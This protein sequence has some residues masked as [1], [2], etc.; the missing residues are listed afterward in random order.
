MNIKRTTYMKKIRP[1]FNKQLIKVLTGQRRVGKS[2]LMLQ[3]MEELRSLNK[4]AN[5]IYIDKE[6]HEFKNII[7]DD[8]LIRYVKENHDASVKNYLFIDEV[9]EI[10]FFE[11]ALRDLVAD[12]VFDIYCTGSN[13]QMFS[14]EL[15]TLLSGRQIELKIYP[16]SYK[17]LLD[18]HKFDN[19]DEALDYYLKYGGLPFLIHLEKDESV[20][21]DYLIN[22]LS[23]IIFR[24]VVNR[25]KV[26]D[27]AFLDSLLSFIA[28]NTGSLFSA[29]KI[30]AYLKSQNISK[31]V[32]SVI[33]YMDYLELA[34]IISKLK[35]MDVQGKKIFEVGGKYYFEDVGLRNTLVGFK[36][37]DINK[38]IEN[39]V[40]NH[41]R[42]CGYSVNIGRFGN[43]EIDFVA[44][45][46]NERIYVQVAYLLKD[47]Q[48]I[49]R[50]FGNLDL[51]RDHY[52]KYVIS[53]DKFP[54]STSYKGIQHYNLRTF[55]STGLL[56]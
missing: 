22:I 42:V 13:S 10:K 11:K 3:I 4:N 2:Y 44:E 52:P 33:S 55:L 9:Q 21:F 17:E 34:N 5:F 56:D 24:D 46:E 53:M 27:A 41:L 29:R 49:Q 15:S 25:N 26:R 28:D 51:V 35:L 54:V 31:S 30:T 45:K 1:F 20:I 7:D 8:S 40:Y 36:A 6:K 38:I 47:E 50:E 18:F 23:T 39:V 19:N 37:Q 14:T 32:T 43:R 12:N 48:T 16:L